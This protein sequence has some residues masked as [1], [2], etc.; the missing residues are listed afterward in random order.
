MEDKIIL[1]EDD[2]HLDELKKRIHT[3]NSGAVVIFNEVVRD[4]NRGKN[5]ES[6]EIQEYP[7]M[8]KEELRK[9]RD[10]SINNFKINDVLIVHRYGIL[11]V[12]HN[13][14]G[15]VVTAPQRDAAFSACKYCIDRLKE[16]VPLWRKETIGG[17]M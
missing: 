8:T 4:K 17:I 5:I 15:I 2:F 12:G 11:N 9:V 14:I 7:E 16:I 13:V 10:E 6:L 3:S 1:T